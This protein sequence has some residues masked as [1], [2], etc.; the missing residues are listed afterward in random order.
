MPVAGATVYLLNAKTGK[1]K[2]LRTNAEGLYK[3]AVDKG[4]SYVTKATQLNYLPDCLS[5]QTV[6]ASASTLMKAP[7]D[8]VLEKLEV[9]KVFKLENILYDLDTWIISRAATLELDKLV[10]IMMENPISVQ[11]GSHTDCHGSFMENDILSQKRA[12]SIVRYIIQKGISK[13]RITAKGFGERYLINHCSDGVECTPAEHQANRRTE[14]RITAVSPTMLQNNVKTF[15][16][17][18]G[19]EIDRGLFAPD[20][21]GN[22][23]VK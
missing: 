7:R 10:K 13:E 15:K 19:D 3:S 23:T 9:N 17:K 11:L 4:G 6:A 21:F 18:E 12:E 20:F 2:V 1:V 5:F 16:H 14:Y 8:L 22:C